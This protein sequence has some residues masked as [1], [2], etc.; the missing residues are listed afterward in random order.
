LVVCSWLHLLKGWS[1]RETRGDSILLL[2]AAVLQDGL[3]EAYEFTN[4]VTDDSIGMLQ[5]FKPIPSETEV[6]K[7]DRK[8]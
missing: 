4:P 5:A 7:E 6:F 1:L 3:P 8:I 2:H